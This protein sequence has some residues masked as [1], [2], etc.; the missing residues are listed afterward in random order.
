MTK[1]CYQKEFP[2]WVYMT[3]KAEAKDQWDP[4]LQILAENS[5]HVAWHS[6]KQLASICDMKLIDIFDPET[7][8]CTSTI[9][10]C[11]REVS[12]LAWSYDGS[13]LASTG[14]HDKII[15]IWDPDSGTRISK[16]TLDFRHCDMDAGALSIKWSRSNTHLATS[17]STE[18]GIVRVWNTDTGNCISSIVSSMGNMGPFHL[19]SSP[20]RNSYIFS[21]SHKGTLIAL[22]WVDEI[23]IWNTKTF[24]RGANLVIKHL[25]TFGGIGMNDESIVSITWLPDDSRLLLKSQSGLF[26]WVLST[27]NHEQEIKRIDLPQW[28][29]S[30]NFF[31]PWLPRSDELDFVCSKNESKIALCSKKSNSICI[32]DSTIGEHTSMLEIGNYLSSQLRCIAWSPDETQLACGYGD[33]TIKVWHVTTRE[34]IFIL[35]GHAEAVSSIFWSEDGSRL[36]SKSDDQTIRVWETPWRLGGLDEFNGF[37]NDTSPVIR[38]DHAQVIAISW[39][40]DGRRLALVT[41]HGKMSPDPTISIWDGCTGERIWQTSVIGSGPFNQISW[42]PNGAWLASL[43][44]GIIMVW[45]MFSGEFECLYAPSNLALHELATHF[46][47]SPSGSK[48]A[49][50]EGAFDSVIRIWKP[51]T[52]E[53]LS[54]LEVEDEPNKVIVSW[55]SD[56]TRLAS[57]S[58][59]KIKV[60]KISTS[61]CIYFIRLE[62]CDWL[63]FKLYDSNILHTQ[64][65]TLY[66]QSNRFEVIK[67]G[68]EET[69]PQKDIPSHRYGLSQSRTWITFNGQYLLWLPPGYRPQ[70]FKLFAVS[71]NSVAMGCSTGHVLFLNFSDIQLPR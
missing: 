44:G 58:N 21:W 52:E 19:C 35:R 31:E 40:P 28:E 1:R 56:E 6:D 68:S 63:Q 47:W 39:S 59:G 24:Q 38:E 66:I 36:L 33:S 50:V 48:I 51:S 61:E 5:L 55:S 13:R 18:P 20:Q 49:S 53:I 29:S 8:K 60:W 42:S 11:S 45:D 69:V 46:V 16:I 64:V 22:A 43:A 32:W 9:E 54:T 25:Q 37:Y 34:C 23:E 30:K 26:L 4:C 15:E 57:L 14:Y 7:G 62:S 71:G 2:Q 27:S 17:S 70:E 10:S 67:S 12:L 41:N 3:G 65:G